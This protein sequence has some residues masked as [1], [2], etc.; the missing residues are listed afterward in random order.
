MYVIYVVQYRFVPID[1]IRIYFAQH[2]DN[3]II[4][5]YDE[6]KLYDMSRKTEPRA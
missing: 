4:E 6:K 5:D 3:L 1:P 2:I